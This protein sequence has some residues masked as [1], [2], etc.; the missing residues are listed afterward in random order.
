MDGRVVQAHYARPPR[1]QLVDRSPQQVG[2]GASLTWSQAV[3]R[4]APKHSSRSRRGAVADPRAAPRAMEE[5]LEPKFIARVTRTLEQSVERRP[6]GRHMI[7][8]VGEWA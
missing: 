5:S 1:E 7:S 8:D 6:P 3:G 4:R 2:T